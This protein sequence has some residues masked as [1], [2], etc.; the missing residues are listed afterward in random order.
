[1]QEKRYNTFRFY[2]RIEVKVKK[3]PTEVS[4]NKWQHEVSLRIDGL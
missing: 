3:N 4:K 1:M 2:I